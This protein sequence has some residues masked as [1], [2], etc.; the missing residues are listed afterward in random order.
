MNLN[1]NNKVILVTGSTRGIGL[2][3][4]N[5][6]NEENAIVVRN[7]RSGENSKY[8]ITADVTKE[9]DCQM[10]INEVIEQHGRLDALICNVGGGDS[11][12]PGTESR[13]DWQRMIE[14]NL[15]SA[16]TLVEYALPYLRNVCGNVI[17]ITSACGSEYFQGAPLAYSVAKSALGS[18]VK[19]MSQITSKVRFNVVSPGNI[20]FEGSI[21]DTFQREQ[22]EIVEKVLDETSLQRF[23]KPEEVASAVC[24]LVSDCASFIT[25]AGINVDGGF[26]RS[27]N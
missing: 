1:L 6:L 10:L 5:A 16:T 27:L 26:T 13:A 19:C 3:I 23:G 2:S 7:S 11:N 12:S 25:G 18:F 15:L 9:S 17:C 21:W 14:M 4:A 24:Y 20:L 8:F 22:P